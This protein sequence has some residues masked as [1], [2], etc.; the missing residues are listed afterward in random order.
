MGLNRALAH[1][2]QRR[3]LH[4]LLVESAAAAQAAAIFIL[5]YTLSWA[6]CSLTVQAVEQH[7]KP[8]HSIGIAVINLHCG[9]RDPDVAPAATFRTLH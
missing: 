1:C 5:A 6:V 4:N 9:W 2:D 7:V 3:P 8:D